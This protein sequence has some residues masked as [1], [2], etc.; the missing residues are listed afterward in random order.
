MMENRT[1]SEITAARN[2]ARHLG[3][4]KE[5]RGLGLRGG[6]FGGGNGIIMNN[7]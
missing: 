1:R 4:S 6:G 5:V 7:E 2:K 3:I